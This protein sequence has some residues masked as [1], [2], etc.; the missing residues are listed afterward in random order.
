M[1]PMRLAMQ[2]NVLSPHYTENLILTTAA[3]GD[4]AGLMGAL[5]LARSR[6]LETKTSPTIAN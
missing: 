4:E 1:E 2:E 5:A 6:T 3:L